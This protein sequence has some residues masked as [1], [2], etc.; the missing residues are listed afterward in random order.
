MVA[1]AARRRSFTEVRVGYRDGPAH[2]P[3]VVEAGRCFSCGVCN[4]C[5]RCRDYCPEGVL[6]RDGD[7]Y[8]IDYGYCKGC[9]VCATACPRGVIYMSEL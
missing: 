1:P 8:R 4:T 2:H 6:L 5:D 7:G 3:A 9:G